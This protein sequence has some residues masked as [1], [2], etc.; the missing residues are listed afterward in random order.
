[1]IY[2]LAR[3][4]TDGQS[5]G[6][7]VKELRAAGAEKVL[8]E[9]AA[10]GPTRAQLRR[11][12]GQLGKGDVLTVTRLDRLARSTR[13]LLNALATI[14]GKGAGFRSRHGQTR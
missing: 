13:D 4:S 14:T 10:Q 1:M 5:L 6:A 9:T 2:G 11:V 7:Q 3:V 12:L 8:R